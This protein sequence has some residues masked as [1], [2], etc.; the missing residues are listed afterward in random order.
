M[1]FRPT[2][3]LAARIALIAVLAV[4]CGAPVCTSLRPTL[5]EGDV[6]VGMPAIQMRV[7]AA[8]PD[9]RWVVYSRTMRDTNGDGADASNVDA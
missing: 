1:P 5:E 4:G 3:P 6:P 2:S 9:Q 8:Q 7:L